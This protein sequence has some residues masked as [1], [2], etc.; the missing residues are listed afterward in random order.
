MIRTKFCVDN[1]T[2][3]NNIIYGGEAGIYAAPVAPCLTPVYY[4]KDLID[5]GPFVNSRYNRGMYIYRMGGLIQ[6]NVIDHVSIG[7]QFLPHREPTGLTA[8]YNDIK[9]YS[10][11]LYNNNQYA[12]SGPHK[13]IANTVGVAENPR[14]TA[15]MGVYLPYT[16]D[17]TFRGI[18][19]INHGL[20]GGTGEPP[21]AE[22]YNNILDGTYD[23]ATTVGMASTTAVRI[24]SANPDSNEGPSVPG[25]KTIVHNNAFDNFDTYINNTTTVNIDPNLLDASGNW[26]GTTDAAALFAGVTAG[27]DYTPWLASG[28]DNDADVAGFQGDFSTLYVDDD[29]FQVGA[30]GRIQEAI[31]L[32]SGSTIYVLPGTYQEAV[33]VDKAVNLYGPNMDVNPNGTVNRG[34]E[35]IIL[36]STT[37]P[38]MSTLFELDAENVVVKGF[39]FDNVR[40]NNYI[41]GGATGTLTNQ[42]GGVDI[43]NNIFTNVSGTAL[44][45]RDGRNA[46]G[47]YSADVTVQNNLFNAITSA[48]GV[49]YNAGSAVVVMGGE[50]LLVDGNVIEDAAYNGIQLA[51]NNN[52]TVSNN[53]AVADQPAIQIAQWNEGTQTISGNDLQ[54]SHASKA[55]MRFYA[56]TADRT[57]SFVIEN[58][59]IHDSVNGIQIGHGD[60]GKGDDISTADYSF[61]GNTF[62]DITGHELVVYLPAEATA[63]QLTEMV[64]DFRQVYDAGAYV[65]EIN[66]V[67]PYTYVVNY[68]PVAVDDAYTVEEDHELVVSAAEGVLANDTDA[69]GDPLTAV[70]VTG[71]T[72]AAVNG[73]T[74]NPDG[75]FSY[76]P[77]QDYFGE[78]TFTYKIVSGETT[79]N[80][81]TVTITVTPVKDPVQAND[82]FYFVNQ[83]AVLEVPAPGVLGNDVDVDLNNQYA[84]LVSGPTHGHLNFRNDGSF[85]YT[86]ETDFFG[87]DT[88][89]YQLITTPRISSDPWVDT[90]TVTITVIPLP[91]ISSPDIEGPYTVGVRRDF[92]VTLTNPADGATYTNLSVS[93]FV[94]DITFADYEKVEV[95]HPVYGTW[96]EL[97]PV[98]DGD[99][100]R[101]DLG[102]TGQFPLVPGQVVTLTFRVTFLTAGTYPAEGSLYDTSGTTPVEIASF[103]ATLTVNNPPNTLPEQIAS[104]PSYV[105]DD[106]YVYVGDFAYDAASLTYTATYTAPEYLAGGA[107]NDLAR[108][109]GALYRQTGATIN[110]VTYKGVD[111]SWNLAE[112]LKGSN[113]EDENGITL[114]SVIV[115]D[116]ANQVPGN[117]T[118]T[119]A[120]SFYTEDVSFVVDA[121]NTL[122]DE[123]ESAP[124]Y[125]YD[126]VYT[127]VGTFAFDDASN[128][129][130]ATYTDVNYNPGAMNDLARYLGALHRQANATVIKVTYKGVDYTWNPAE[131]L[132]GS[133][134]EDENGTTLVSVVTADFQNGL[135]DPA[136]GL[137][138]TVS[139]GIHTETV[140]FIIV[141]N[142]TTAPE[143]VSITAIGADGFENVAA[144]NGVITVDQ[145]YTVDRAE[146]VLNEV[147][148]VEAG[149]VVSIGGQPYGTITADGTKLT[150][151][152]YAGNEIASL[153][154]TFEFSVPAG[155]VKD[156]AGNALL[157]LDVTLIVNNVAPVA[158]DD[159]YTTEEDTLLTV[160]KPG[161]LANDVDWTP[162]TVGLVG[163][164]TANGT[165]TLNADGSF[166]YMP[167]A[168]WHGT[169]SF[170]YKVS[171]GELESNTATVTIT[172]TPVKDPVNAVDDFYF[173]NENAVLTVPAP[174]VMANDKDPD[175]NERRVVLDTDVEHGTLKLNADGSFIYTPDADW[176]GEDSFIYELITYPKTQSLWTDTATVTITVHPV[177]DAPVLDEI[178]DATIP[179]MVLFS[180]TATATDVDSTNLTFSLINA[181]DGASI[182]ATTGV[183]TWTPTEAQGPGVYEFTVKVCDN[184]D[185]VLCDEQLITLTVE[186]VNLPPVLAEIGDQVVEAGEELTFT[187]TATDPDLPV[188]TLTFSLLGAP[189]G[190]S[191]DPATGVFTWTP[192]VDQAGDHTVT[193]CV[194]DGELEDCEEITITV[195]YINLA[196]VAVADTYTTD[197]DVVLTVA[198]PGVLE[199]DSDP[200][201]DALTA[202]LVDG[203]DHGTLTFNADGSF[204]YTPEQDYNGTDSFTYKASDGELESEVVTVTITI[205]PVNDAPVAVDDAYTTAEDVILVVAA[206][207]VLANDYDVDGDTLT[208]TLRTG[209]SHGTLTLMSDG[210]FTYLPDPDFFG[211]D[212]FTY[213]LITYPGTTSEWTDWATVTITV[214]P[215]ND[216][217]VLDEIPDATIPEM[218]LYT[219]TATATDV[220]STNLTFSLINPPAGAS[221]NPTT[222]VFTWT[223]TEAQG[224]GVFTF[225]VKVCDDGTPVLC[226][227]PLLAG[228]VL[229]SFTY[230]AYDG[231]MY[232]DVTTVTIVVDNVAPE[233]VSITAIGA[234]GFENVVAVGS[235]AGLLIRLCQNEQKSY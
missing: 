189:D 6:N 121:T 78:D 19:V 174:G 28:T 170:T 199:N 137:T 226:Q 99:G 61:A 155:S 202:I 37:A 43:S 159:A 120:D 216:A 212:S 139:D 96:V 172:V 160:A 97:T 33:V 215:V 225:T 130:T 124:A 45:L 181:P 133:N 201:G 206:P 34:P 107:M 175:G 27:S 198:A 49:D 127:Y 75:S 71:P 149:T 13:W 192:T 105:Y 164:G 196:P 141:I 64:E 180:F 171:D 87:E 18:H 152:P 157:D 219:F 41:D 128:T 67:D 197:E 231:Q 8:Q 53:T 4:R 167:N 5:G 214:T 98:I 90:A 12:G 79:S 109:L 69:E 70:L 51:R 50:N 131:P 31:D 179:E 92:H 14:G 7:I 56:F 142:D 168:N 104:A 72:H 166:S 101:L 119:V 54:T 89:V 178:A 32:V 22:F 30:V 113:W 116:L 102:P 233:L 222:G 47:E 169:D 114:V 191:I 211:T 55:A 74:L 58:N 122:D 39:T 165:L 1:L 154:G 151:V 230:K 183:F 158:N 76:K 83:N 195:N 57:P 48:G 24:S 42:F 184:G 10:I 44:Y 129:Y 220:D 132:K 210:S 108:Y 94:D 123:I 106:G 194:S 95:L 188:Q 26:W 60:A 185:P 3:K 88:F 145:G 29:S 182:N 65:K 80:I 186:E 81:A 156:L 68:A 2:N 82:D 208:A 143:I 66:G 221:I 115:A 25:T 161:V 21:L 187:A 134:W 228:M 224:P 73:F 117:L 52:V 203:V 227:R 40:I 140:T 162:L 118:L 77:G 213:N 200:N 20:Y 35:A 235:N 36:G 11:G 135:I 136:T 177:N 176:S 85:T 223:P 15:E 100:L 234:A 125:V 9:A 91:V 148:T 217:P 111:Y 147:V 207:G 38:A 86:P 205:N 232:S 204:V 84:A 229:D 146:I 144:V 173:V 17:V 16:T 218:V 190:A 163:E 46:P 62:T 23:P 126:P 138:F 93:V 103:S 112:P 110:K 153:P 150:V 63:D 193:V 209:V 59:V